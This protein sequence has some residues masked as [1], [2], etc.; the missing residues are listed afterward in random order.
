MV[1]CLGWGPGK[2]AEKWRCPM[3][4]SS[5]HLLSVNWSITNLGLASYPRYTNST[6]MSIFFFSFDPD[7]LN[8]ATNQIMQ[9]NHTLRSNQSA[10]TNRPS[11]QISQSTNPIKL[12]DLA[13]HQSTSYQHC[14]IMQET[15]STN[16]TWGMK[17]P[18]TFRPHVV[19]NKVL[20]T[21]INTLS[22][23]FYFNLILKMNSF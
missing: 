19:Q 4:Y 11:N 8:H 22:L 17:W 3:W 2:S 1:A 13:T 9:R 14:Q 6:E 18:V 15:Q 23:D 12:S 10:Q 7:Q 5:P 21:F 20:L 16:H